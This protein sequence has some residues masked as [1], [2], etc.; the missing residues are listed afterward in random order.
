MKNSVVVYGAG[1]K[2]LGEI[3]PHQSYI[4][5]LK[6]TE[7]GPSSKPF[8]W[9]EVRHK[10]PVWSNP[11]AIVLWAWRQVLSSIDD[12]KNSHMPSTCIVCGEKS[13][14]TKKPLFGRKN[15]FVGIQCKNPKCKMYGVIIPAKMF[16]ADVKDI[17][18]DKLS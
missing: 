13:I 18:W 9:M 12:I 3:E 4:D 17:P 14:Y 11:E 8:T 10:V 5:F 1:G 15:D 16:F 7:L 6:T 2:K